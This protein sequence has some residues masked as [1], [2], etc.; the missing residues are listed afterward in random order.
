MTENKQTNINGGFLALGHE[1]TEST[2][3]F[4]EE[5]HVS[6]SACVTAVRNYVLCIDT[7]GKKVQTVRRKSCSCLTDQSINQSVA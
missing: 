7:C 4:Q 3:E 5:C 1:S 6:F 2:G